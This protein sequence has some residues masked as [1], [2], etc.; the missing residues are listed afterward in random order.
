MQKE[1][2]LNKINACKD[3]IGM[4]NVMLGQNSQADFIMGYYYNQNSGMYDV[5]INNER[6]RHRIRLSTTDELMALEKLL[7]MIECRI[8]SLQGKK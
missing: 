4:R 2:Y 8:E 6:G 7:S 1:E 3:K 5:Y